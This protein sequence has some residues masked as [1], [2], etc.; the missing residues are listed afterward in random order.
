MPH[1]PSA[2]TGGTHTLRNGLLAALLAAIA[3]AALVYF[4]GSS[5]SSQADTDVARAVA[6][7]FLQ[8]LAEH[9]TQQA[10]LATTSEFKSAQGQERFIQFVEQHPLLSKPLRLVSVQ[11]ASI[12]GSPRAECLFQAQASQPLVHVLIGQEGSDWRVDRLL[13]DEPAGATP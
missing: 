12:D 13:V 2:T 11:T 7:A 5:A 1:T 4:P 9:Q 10:W 8:Q 6:E 3:I